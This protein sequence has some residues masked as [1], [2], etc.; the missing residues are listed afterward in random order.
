MT[1]DGEP[2]GGCFRVQSAS[3][4]KGLWESS[5]NSC[6]ACASVTSQKFVLW[7]KSKIF[8]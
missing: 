5:V 3:I 4:W 1:Q 6:E 7:N 2:V 8:I